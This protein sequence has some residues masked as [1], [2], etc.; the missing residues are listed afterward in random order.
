MRLLLRREGIVLGQK[1]AVFAREDVVC[2]CGYGETCSQ[3]LAQ[4]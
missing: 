4:G 1:L 3:V 2:Y